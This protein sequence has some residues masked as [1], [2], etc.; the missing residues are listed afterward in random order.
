[1]LYKIGVPKLDS[2]RTL[3]PIGAGDAVAAGTL[4]AWT[5]FTGSDESGAVV[6]KSCSDLLEEYAQRIGTKSPETYAM[7]A[8]AFGLVCGSASC[9]QEEN[10]VLDV[11]DVKKL[12][13][14]SGQPEHVLTQSFT[15]LQKTASS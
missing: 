3:Y 6:P 10:S 8:F 2:S 15:K 12:F 5:T 11:E 9:L 1:M 4:A 14:S 13:E 7:S